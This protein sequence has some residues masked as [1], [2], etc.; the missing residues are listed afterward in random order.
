[1]SDQTPQGAQREP[2]DGT[3]DP[4]GYR[5]RPHYT[6]E[7]APQPHGAGGHHDD[8]RPSDDQAYIPPAYGQPGYSQPGYGQ[9]AY[10]QPGPGQPGY[11][12]PGYGPRG[13]GQPGPGQPGYHEGPGQ[14]G[15][16]QG[17]G[18][19]GYGGPPGFGP[20][21]GYGG[22]PGYGQ[23]GYGQP[24]YAGYRRTNSK[25]IWSLGLSIAS[26]VI[27]PAAIAA[28]V[29]GVQAKGEI[30]HTHEDGDG[31]ATAGIVIGAVTCALGAL[32]LLFFIG[33]FASFGTP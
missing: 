3:G 19:P 8:G 5:G 25:A 26:W 4:P 11:G 1:M 33:V 16:D 20:P 30:R 13:P 24:G 10:G 17:P 31:M 21:P 27:W 2:W 32:F 29:I 28:V 7:P 14:P 15:Y 22:A 12:G 18:Q 23:P 6:T 9:P